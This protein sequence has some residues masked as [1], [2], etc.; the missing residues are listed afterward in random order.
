LQL[1]GQK[2]NKNEEKISSSKT[3]LITSQEAS[4]SI[5]EK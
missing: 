4:H 1:A 5:A 3:K 2:E